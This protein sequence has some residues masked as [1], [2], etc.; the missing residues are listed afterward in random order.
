MAAKAAHPLKGAVARRLRL[1]CWRG[2]T[3]SRSVLST[4]SYGEKRRVNL[5][6][7]RTETHSGIILPSALRDLS[8]DARRDPECDQILKPVFRPDRL[9]EAREQKGF[10]LDALGENLA[11]SVTG[12]AV[13]RW[14][15]GETRPRSFRI[16]DLAAALDKPEEY[17]LTSTG[18]EINAEVLG[19]FGQERD[20][21]S[22]IWKMF[23]IM[24]QNEGHTVEI[25]LA[26]VLKTSPYSW[27]ALVIS[28]SRQWLGVCA[29]QDDFI[30][31]TWNNIERTE[32]A[33]SILRKPSNLVQFV[34][35]VLLKLESTQE[36]VY[37]RK[38]LA[39]IC[40]GHKWDRVDRSRHIMDAPAGWPIF[41]GMSPD[42]K[43]RRVD[44]AIA[45]A[46]KAEFVPEHE[47]LLLRIGATPLT[48]TQK[49]VA[50]RLVD[51][52]TI[53]DEIK[54]HRGLWSFV[55]KLIVSGQEPNFRADF[56]DMPLTLTLDWP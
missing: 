50:G 15:S 14:E 8:R 49:R 52:R 23:L 31:I 42:Q 20:V 36:L 34:A 2:K 43:Q 18:A 17:F 32:S 44:G 45:T 39:N 38:A 13:A 26:F 21:L 10:T 1:S 40:F 11:H 24:P 25:R 16:R 22:G 55:Q 29:G 6:N 27:K 47:A 9:R 37:R 33:F 28:T 19:E 35:G 4:V 48:R 51:Y 56:L 7:L 30:S 53:L 46:L 12:S 54:Q 3:A 5:S 41:N